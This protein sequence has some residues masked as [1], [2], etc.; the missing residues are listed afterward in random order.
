MTNSRFTLDT[1]VLVDAHDFANPSRQA[2]AES[3]IR[4][5]ALVGFVLTQQ[6][7]GE[8]YFVVTRKGH[9]APSAAALRARRYASMFPLAAP[10]AAALDRALDAAEKGRFAFWDA[11]LLAAADEAGC[12]VC[13]S[14][15]MPDGAKLGSITVRRTFDGD[16]LS[17]AAQALLA[18]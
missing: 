12:T 10:S 4:A 5:A 13:L 18:P 7:I 8:F 9:A 1:T 11:Y 15:D 6:S 3:L 14:T 16:A 17:K 2:L